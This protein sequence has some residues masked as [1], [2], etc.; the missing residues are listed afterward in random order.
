MN[1]LDELLKKKAWCAISIA[2]MSD[3][4]NVLVAY[5]EQIPIQN[6]KSRVNTSQKSGGYYNSNKH[7]NTNVQ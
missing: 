7:C 5:W 3:L 6:L 1:N 4:N 2:A